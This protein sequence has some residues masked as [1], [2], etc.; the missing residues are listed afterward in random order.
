MS[1]RPIILD[2]FSGT[3]SFSR[4][5]INRGYRV[6]S[7]DTAPDSFGHPGHKRLSIMDVDPNPGEPVVA[8][9][10]SPPC[11][12]FSI[13]AIGRSWD[14]DTGLP[15]SKSAELGMKLLERSIFLIAQISPQ[16]FYIEN[17]RGMMR[18][19][20]D[21]LL[22][23]WGLSGATIRHTVSYCQY[24]DTRM[25]PTDIWTNDKAW[26]PRPMCKNGDPCHEAAPRGSK[27]ETQGVTGARERS[28]VPSQLIEEIL[29]SVEKHK[30]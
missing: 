29:D 21:P 26:V 7:Y 17:P 11:Q 4:A 3:G 27:T 22:E 1:R 9:W 23:R 30:R 15:K 8:A 5:A 2:I 16:F 12:G 24:G 10:F 19:K 6:F 14:K 28:R 18:K 20:I 25:K 13:A